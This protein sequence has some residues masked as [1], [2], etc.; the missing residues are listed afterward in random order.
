MIGVAKAA[1]SGGAAWWNLSEAAHAAGFA[2]GAHMSRSFRRMLGMPPS[3]LRH[4]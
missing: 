4:A 1:R 3:A 2:D